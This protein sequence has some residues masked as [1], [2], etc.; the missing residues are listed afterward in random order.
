M[1]SLK[2]GILLAILIITTKMIEP[3]PWW[4]FVVPVFCL[5]VILTLKKWQVSGFRLGL[6]WGFLTFLGTNLFFHLAY[7]GRIFFKL[8]TAVG[9][10][11]WLISAL[12]GGLLTGLAFYSGQ[13]MVLDKK[14]ALKL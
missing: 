8:G 2:A 10:S 4:G 11:I 5:G 1:D 6:L 12:I 9:V 14:A 7:N 3:A 13:V